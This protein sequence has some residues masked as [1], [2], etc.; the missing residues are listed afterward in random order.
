MRDAGRGIGGSVAPCFR[1]VCS[2]G[3]RFFTDPRSDGGVAPIAVAASPL[4]SDLL[5]LTRSTAKRRLLY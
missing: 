1:N 2:G 4:H 3:K 5:Q